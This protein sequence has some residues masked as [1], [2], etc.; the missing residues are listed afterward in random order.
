MRAD[1]VSAQTPHIDSMKTAIQVEGL[2]KQYRLGASQGAAYRTLRESLS[3]AASRY[4]GQMRR[5]RPA[6]PNR[7]A[8]APDRFWA[9][10]DVSFGVQPGEVVGIIGRNGAGKSTL[11]KILT[12]I[13]EPTQGRASLRGRVG[14]LLEVGTGFHPELTGR[15]NIYMN[16]SI[17]GMHR[18]EIKRNFDKIVDF[19]EVERFIDTPVKRYSSG[20]HVRL[21]FAVAAHLNPEILIVDEVLAV[22]DAEFQKKCLGKMREVARAGRTVLFVS[23]NMAT[24]EHLCTRSILLDRGRVSYDG[25]VPDAFSAYQQSI[26]SDLSDEDLATLPRDPELQPVIRKLRFLDDT[27]RP[28]HSLA[29]GE[30]MVIEIVYEATAPLVSPYF[31]LRFETEHGVRVFWV[32]TRLQEKHFPD[33]PSKGSVLCRIPELPLLPGRYFITPGCGTRSTQLDLVPRACWI[34]VAA[35]DVFGTG[36]LPHASLGLVA[37]SASWRPGSDH[38]YSEK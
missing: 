4:W 1:V 30:A 31:G 37:V 18:H 17:L 20:M 7:E 27:L 25:A 19:A 34:D 3:Q 12:R 6:R 24:V 8:T 28:T 26:A 5:F 32:Q 13:T 23:H 29:T 22:G 38:E 11:L 10:D 21:A 33:L 14:S 2:S 16:G 15:E 9:I 36:R 35:R